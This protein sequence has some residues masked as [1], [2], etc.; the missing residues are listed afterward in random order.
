[1]DDGVCDCC[2]GSDEVGTV[3]C[4][5]VC[6]K[7]GQSKL[8]GLES[9]LADA[10]A[11]LRRNA[12]VRKEASDRRAGWEKRL[13]HLEATESRT[14]QVTSLIARPEWLTWF[15]LHSSVAFGAILVTTLAAAGW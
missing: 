2:D 15:S 3:V 5:D 1:M 12:V 13:E 11:G 8:A 9:A 6:V 10:E 4:P 14:A 7:E